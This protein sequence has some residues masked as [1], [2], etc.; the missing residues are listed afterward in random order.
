MVAKASIE[1]SQSSATIPDSCPVKI[2]T[3]RLRSGN[4]LKSEYE[5]DSVDGGV[6][7]V[8]EVERGDW[9]L[10]SNISNRTFNWF[11]KMYSSLYVGAV[12][13]I[14]GTLSGIITL[15]MIRYQ[16]IDNGRRSHSH[17]RGKRTA[18]RTRTIK[19]D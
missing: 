9:E 19:T 10:F 12:I 8:G 7:F 6:L 16:L 3:E 15:I 18:E 11:V 13:C 2:G 4:R 17:D 5:R 14:G 1:P